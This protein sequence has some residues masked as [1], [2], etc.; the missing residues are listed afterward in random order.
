[1]NRRILLPVVPAAL[2]AL[3]LTACGSDEPTSASDDTTPASST[4]TPADAPAFP[5]DVDLPEHG[6]HYWAVVL[7]P[8]DT[9]AQVD[10]TVADAR[11]YGYDAAIGELGCI[12]GAAEAIGAESNDIA[13]SLLFDTKADA[14]QFTEAYAAAE[15]TDPLTVAKV[16][17]YC[18]D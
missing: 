8:F 17:A 9:E 12:S 7:T 5:D 14:T 10:Q 4:T 11:Q 16:T 15:G 1:M 3:G 18:L 13:A 2:L 6:G